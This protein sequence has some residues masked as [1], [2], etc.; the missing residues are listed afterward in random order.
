M[1]SKSDYTR[2]LQCPKMLWMR[3]HMPEAADESV[4]NSAVIEQGHEVGNLAKG[5]FGPYIEVENDFDF[6]AMAKRTRALIAAA[7]VEA[8]TAARPKTICEATFITDDNL[9]C[10]ADLITVN[11]DGSLSMIEVKSSTKVKPYHLDDA[12]FQAHVIEECGF[13]VSNVSIMHVDSGYVR[14]GELNLKSFMKLEDVSDEVDGRIAGIAEEVSSLRKAEISKTEPDTTIGKH[15]NSPHPCPFQ[16][17]CW[18]NMPEKSVF[19]L[20]GVGRT[21]GWAWWEKGIRT[22]E[23]AAAAMKP[24]GLREAQASQSSLARPELLRDFLAMLS[25]PLYHLD[26]ETFQTAVPKWDGCKPYQ[27]IT[28]QFSL[29]VQQGPGA[30]PEHFEFLAEEGRDPRRSVA[31]ALV[32]AI[33]ADACTLAY[34]MSFERGRIKELAEAFP[35]LSGHLMAIRDGM[36]DLMV[37]FQKGWLY[38]PEMGSSYSIKA[39][40]PAFFPDDPELDYH[41]LDGVHNG[42]EASAAFL[43]LEGMAPEERAR[44]RESLLRYCELDTYAMVKV[45][46]AVLDAAA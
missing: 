31:E 14:N 34:N 10:M 44:T 38:R 6:A 2:G 26:F 33:P 28:S 18:R 22:Y 35:D 25:W 7:Q 13:T 4:C 21:R 24:N 15:C 40:L 32:A 8:A 19:D 12:A 1:F 37:P 17:W 43:A 39:V 46:D 30:T 29:H 3:K 16:G 27:Q 41:A 36:R 20:A 5:Y 11:S 45:L 23:Q 42:S 9:L